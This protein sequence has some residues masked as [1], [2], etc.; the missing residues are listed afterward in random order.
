M[1]AA[2]DAA[3][4]ETGRTEPEA[5]AVGAYDAAFARYRALYPALTPTFHA[6]AEG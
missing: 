5:A 4:R 3:V 2:C 1:D 6:L